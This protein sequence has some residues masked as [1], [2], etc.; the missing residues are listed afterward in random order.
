MKSFSLSVACRASLRGE[1][2]AIRRPFLA[3]AVAAAAFLV[4]GASAWAQTNVTA[5][6]VGT[7]NWS[8]TS[9][10]NC[11][12]PINGAC[13]PN[14]G[15][16]AGDFYDVTIDS[17]TP[18]N[19]GTFSGITIDNSPTIETLAV[20]SGT[21]LDTST[22]QTLTIGSSNNVGSLTN[23]GNIYLGAAGSTIS[24]GLSSDPNATVTISAGA[25]L[26]TGVIPG[27]GT[28]STLF[29]VNGN[30]SNS[31]AAFP[32]YF[33]GSGNL[34][35]V[36]GTFTNASGGALTVYGGTTANI[37]TLANFGNVNVMGGG[38]LNL[39][40]GIT[41]IA[42]GSKLNVAG[43][44]NGLGGLTTVAGTL[45][46]D[47]GISGAGESATP[48]G[49]TLSV[50]STGVLQIGG[51]GTGP[52]VNGSVA[53]SGQV[54]VKK[55]ASLSVTGTYMQTGGSTD[56]NGTLIS[57]TLSI[58][59]G[60]L[61]GSGTIEGTP[62]GGAVSV[63]FS[64][65]TFQPSDPMSIPG[66]L[67]LDSTDT[68][69]EL[70]SGPSN[71]GAADVVGTP[72]TAALGGAALDITTTNIGSLTNGET[73]TILDAVGGV[74]GTFGTINGIDFGSGDSWAVGYSSDTVTL[75]A[76]IPT[77]TTT[78]EPTSLLLL[79]TGLLVLTGVLR[80]KWA[81]AVR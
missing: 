31:G 11:G 42:S 68:W 78:P 2:S 20:N 25:H 36:T 3:M 28:A 30:L 27:T 63:T 72:G 81:A 59:G 41:S 79:G 33:G 53:N 73:F 46:V 10:W 66:S 32:G 76:N 35:N 39:T 43:S 24:V 37:G 14:N 8:A 5:S 71:Y 51:A 67:T 65:A 21:S 12:A 62:T 44:V 45:V 80:R 48:S 15:T 64:H 40:N 29:Q 34:F 54:I 61:R 18:S 38:T 19:T 49:G 16:P 50:S 60:T 75:T 6:S 9:R 4:A 70:W 47:N 58:S 7:G 17:G 23:A 22:A 57:P 13:E 74:S 1:P 77:T 56:V 52:S 69:N 55:G 26:V